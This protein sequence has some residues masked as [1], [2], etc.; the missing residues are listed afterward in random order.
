MRVALIYNSSSGQGVPVEQVRRALS[1]AGLERVLEL[2]RD[3]GFSDALDANLDFVVVAG[4]DGTVQTAARALSGSGIPIAVLA[5]GT[6]NNVAR[7]LGIE[8]HG[9][10]KIATWNPNHRV[11][12]DFG[13]ARGPGAARAFLESVG[14]GLVAAAIAASDE[15]EE[16][17]GGAPLAEAE[18]KRALA[19]YRDTL[20]RLPSRP[21]KLTLD[22]DQVCD[23]L[24][25]VE[26]LNTPSIGPNML[27][28]PNADPSD[29]WLEVVTA[30]ER[31]RHAL[32]DYLRKRLAGQPATL[33]LPTRRARCVEL[34]YSGPL[35]IDDTVG[36]W[37]EHRLAIEVQRAA[38]DFLL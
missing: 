28:A 26:V 12:F 7:C 36:H 1:S 29:G 20:S 38:V 3:D 18:I 33:A 37:R 14:G 35:H 19:I 10:D 24:L 31:D 34:G 30:G 6:A 23:D 27:L 17:Y 9:L 32:E 22:G 11:A 15:H 2:E 8:G 21:M 13:V 5:M 16:R 4:G 25:L